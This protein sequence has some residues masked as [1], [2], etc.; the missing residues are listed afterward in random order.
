MWKRREGRA[1]ERMEVVKERSK[2]KDKEE[3]RSGEEG[4]TNLAFTLISPNRS[5]KCFFSNN[6]FLLFKKLNF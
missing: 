6:V 3:S 4:T 5:Q 1:G 2:E